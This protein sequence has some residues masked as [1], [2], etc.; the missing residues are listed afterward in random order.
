MSDW[1]VRFD[2]GYGLFDTDTDE[3]DNEQSLEFT[4]RNANESDVVAWCKD[5]YNAFAKE[6]QEHITG[7]TAYPTDKIPTDSPDGGY[8]VDVLNWT[9]KPVEITTLQ[10]DTRP[11]EIYYD[12]EVDGELWKDQVIHSNADLVKEQYH[13]VMNNPIIK[14]SNVRLVADFD[15]SELLN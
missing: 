7:I 6:V 2:F 3:Y 12:A 8:Y 5:N 1:K 14:A 9:L 15:V 10:L 13:D 4:F 11:I